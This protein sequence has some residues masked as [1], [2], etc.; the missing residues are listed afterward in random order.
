MKKI[1]SITLSI[2]MMLSVVIALPTV[3][4]EQFTS[5]DFKYKILEDGTASI[6][7]YLGFDKDIMDVKI[8]GEIDGYKVTKVSNRAFNYHGTDRILPQN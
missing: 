7:K 5:G 2:I 3:S 4:A 1:L 8:P 6:T